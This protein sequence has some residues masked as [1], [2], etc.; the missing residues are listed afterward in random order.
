MQATY[1]TDTPIAVALECGDL[2]GWCDEQEAQLL[3]KAHRATV[4]SRKGDRM[5]RIVLVASEDIPLEGAAKT[6][7][8]AGYRG[9]TKY[10]YREELSTCSLIMLKRSLPNG[11]FVPWPR[12]A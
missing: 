1:S 9:A 5:R 8:M 11:S 4:Q 10:T 7:A 12:S 6:R 2:E 3:I